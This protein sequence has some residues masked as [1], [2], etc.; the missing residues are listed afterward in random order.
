MA[1]HLA[2]T[3]DGTI[4]P[5]GHNVSFDHRFL[6]CEFDRAGVVIPDISTL[7]TMRIAGGGNLECRCR[8]LGIEFEPDGAHSALEDARAAARLLASLLR[9]RLVSA[10]ELL[11]MAPVAW[12]RVSHAVATPLPRDLA[13]QRVA[14]AP[15]YLR[16]ILSQ[17]GPFCVMAIGEEAALGYS[18]LLERV[19]ENRHIDQREGAALVALAGSQAMLYG[20]FTRHTLSEPSATINPE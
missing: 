6:R 2:Q 7:C 20:C 15:V 9:E 12:P 5:A 8:D 10:D 11:E 14:E 3:F 13:R 1:G 19:L 17:A 4:A 18:G 16:R